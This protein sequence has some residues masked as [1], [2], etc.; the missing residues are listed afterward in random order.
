MTKIS[1]LT[2]I[3]KGLQELYT[4]QLL[5]L[6]KRLKNETVFCNA[7]KIRKYCELRNTSAP[8]DHVTLSAGE[9]LEDG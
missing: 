8:F 9:A 7:Y 1:H 6:H 2:A 5:F 4:S 3:I